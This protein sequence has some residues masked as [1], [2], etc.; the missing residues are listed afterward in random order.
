M[1]QSAPRV[2]YD[3]NIFVQS[4]ISING[5]AGR[6]VRKAQ[7]GEVSLFV[8]AFILHEIRESHRK[9]PARAFPFLN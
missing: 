6:C 7:S 9:I 3:C 4:L 2:V 8:T 5:P 1:N